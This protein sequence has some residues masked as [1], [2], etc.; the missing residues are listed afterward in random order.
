M[1]GSLLV[2]SVLAVSA[3]WD[4]RLV[5]L[6]IATMLMVFAAAAAD[7]SLTTS[8]LTHAT[9]SS[10]ECN[11]ILAHFADLPAEKDAREI[12]LLPN[13]NG[14]M[15][16]SRINRFSEQPLPDWV[17]ERM[18]SASALLGGGGDLE[19]FRA[20]ITFNLLHEFDDNEGATAFDWHA[21]TKPGDGKTRS[22]NVNVMLSSP[23]VDFGGGTLQVGTDLK[24]DYSQGD[25]IVYPAAVP[26]RVTPL[27]WGKRHTLV[28][29]LTD[30][31]TSKPA[32]NAA[33]TTEDDGP[34]AFAVSPNG[35]MDLR[36]DFAERRRSYWERVEQAF[37]DIA[38]GPLN[39]PKLHILHGE[40]LEGLPG[41]GEDARRAFCR[42]Y[43][44]EGATA[45]TRH[46]EQFLAD[47]VAALQA[48][49]GPKLELA[50]SYFSMAACIQPSHQEAQE[51]LSVVRD[52]LQQVAAAAKKEAQEE[53][54]SD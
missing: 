1:D 25:L 39:E 51:A 13:M 53:K 23:G 34:E 47:G 26:H 5:R 40:F 4:A 54:G 16:V 35:V 44:A 45:A 29:A 46:L 17:Y 7:S 27:T 38:K 49:G 43:I 3:A 8:E 28:V 19:S 52:A 32:A 6:V 11:K 48:E 18:L 15:S 37:D 24:T 9:F 2:A 41:R 42:A 36:E 12:P 30:G 14:S 21:D 22:L 20:N 31:P 10:D 33:A 50:E